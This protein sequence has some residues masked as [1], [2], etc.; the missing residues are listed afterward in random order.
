MFCPEAHLCGLENIKIYHM[1]QKLSLLILCT[2]LMISTAMGQDDMMMKKKNDIGLTVKALVMDYLS[3]NGGDFGAFQKYHSGIEFGVIKNLNGPIN[4]AVPIKLGVVQD[5]VIEGQHRRLIGIDALLQYKI[6]KDD[7]AIVPYLLA[8]GGY[9]YEDPG[10]SHLQIPFGIGFNFRLHDRA[11]VTFQS[12]YRYAL[13]DDRNNLHHGLGITYFLGEKDPVQD[14]IPMQK[15]EMDTMDSD[16]DGIADELDLCPQE[17]GPAEF[18]G[19]PDGDEDGVPDYKDACPEVFGAVAMR[20]CPDSDGDGVSDN[21][22]E[23]PNMAGSPENNGCPDNDADDDGIPN[24]LDRCPTVAGPA[25]NNGCPEVDGDGDGTPDN[26]DECPQVAGPKN[27]LGCPDRDEDGIRDSEDQCPNLPGSAVNNGCPDNN[28]DTD[29]DGVPDVIDSCPDQPGLSLYSGCPDT[30]GDG[31]PDNLDNCP[32]TS[33]PATNNGCPEGQTTDPSIQANNDTDGDGVLDEDDLC[34]RRPGLAV[35]RGCPDTD[36]DGIDDSRDRCP[37]AAGPVD[38]EGCPTVEASDRRVLEIAMRSVQFEPGK[39]EIKE[40]SFNV[41]RQIASIV[42]RYPDFDLKIEGHT[43]N[44]GD[45]TDNLALSQK[46]A[47]ACYNFLASSGVPRE[48]MTYI[49]YGEDRPIATN[50]TISGRTLN[51][52]VEFAL[53]PQE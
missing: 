22:D 12:E 18:D 11:F 8:G 35:Y 46:R 17:A 19:C 9:V 37:T 27:T 6:A 7:S 3:Q 38:N 31:I 2:T 44:L 21:E 15:E 10:T 5:A 47:R 50:E 32:N 40:V 34:P 43:D 28:Q 23:C 20:G 26:I 25:T 14:S 33:G 16:G 48:R 4:I 36:G 29:G 1:K 53:V 51:R 49:G 24:E 13:E 45:E 42:D 41:L 39:A 30:D 52:R